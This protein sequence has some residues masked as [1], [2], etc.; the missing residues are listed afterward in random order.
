LSA[1]KLTGRWAQ[2]SFKDPEGGGSR[3][4]QQNGGPKNLSPSKNPIFPPAFGRTQKDQG[5]RS[6]TLKR[7]LDGRGTLKSG[8]KGLLD[9]SERGRAYLREYQFNFLLKIQSLDGGAVPPPPTRGPNVV[10][11]GD[12]EG[13]LGARME[14][15]LRGPRRQAADDPEGS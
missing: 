1:F 5:Y 10:D 3:G 4:N 7:S 8:G 14:E 13:G 9:P 11:T 6:P 15:L 2:A 12:G